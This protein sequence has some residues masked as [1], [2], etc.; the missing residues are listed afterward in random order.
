MMSP[1]RHNLHRLSGI[2][3]PLREK[4]TISRLRGFTLIEVLVVVAIIATL[5]VLL[6]PALQDMT[7]KS[8]Q[9]ICLG[10]VRSVGN[11]TLAYVAD[12]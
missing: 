11:A 4:L 10:N 5:S 7:R 3:G 6:L 8:K 12:V 1:L 2:C 9:A